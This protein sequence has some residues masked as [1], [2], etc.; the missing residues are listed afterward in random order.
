VTSETD[1]HCICAG[2]PKIDG[3][4]ASR[5]G[6]CC[7][8]DANVRPGQTTYFSIRS[9]CNSFDYDCNNFA[10][11]QYT[12]YGTCKMEL[13]TCNV[14]KAGWS[15]ALPNCGETGN[16][17]TDCSYNFGVCDTTTQPRDQKCR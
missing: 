3:Y 17:L 8:Q 1:F 16:W 2:Q 13:V 5:G 14:S 4:T 15:G 7:D 12:D 10:S 6:D 11:Q 9:Q